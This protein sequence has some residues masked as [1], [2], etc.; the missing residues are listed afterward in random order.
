[1]YE[2]LQGGAV[3]PLLLDKLR[4]I[5]YDNFRGDIMTANE[6][7]ILHRYICGNFGA[8]GTCPIDDWVPCNTET[9]DKELVKYAL[10]VYRKSGVAGLQTMEILSRYMKAVVV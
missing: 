4:L 2:L 9:P 3:L 1:M 7:E 6:R 10:I 5:C 8:C